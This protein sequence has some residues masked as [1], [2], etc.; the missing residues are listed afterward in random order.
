M[1]QTMLAVVTNAFVNIYDLTKDSICPVYALTVEGQRLVDAVVIPDSPEQV[2]VFALTASGKIYK[3]LLHLTEAEHGPLVLETVVPVPPAVQGSCSA[4]GSLA[5][6]APAHLFFCSFGDGKAFVADRDLD[7][8]QLQNFVDL[9]DVQDSSG[10]TTAST[11]VKMM[12]HSS[13]VFSA[14]RDDDLH[15]N[16]ALHAA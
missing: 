5:Y 15:G 2:D 6:S 12:P 1:L 3:R 8:R 9:S 16:Q 10:A 7:R 11:R 4:G 13:W 14:V